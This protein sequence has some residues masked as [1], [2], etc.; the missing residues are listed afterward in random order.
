MTFALLIFWG[1]DVIA[2]C[3][4]CNCPNFT[5][6]GTVLSGTLLPETNSMVKSRRNNN[7]NN[8]FIFRGL[9]IM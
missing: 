3:V 4:N 8:V 9:H 2:F 6:V 5:P 7:N 1:A